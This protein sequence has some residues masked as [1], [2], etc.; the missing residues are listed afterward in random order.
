MGT[1]SYTYDDFNRL[2][3]G[4]AT[5]GVDNTLSL[6]WTYDRGPQRQ[7]FVAGVE[8]RYGNRWAQNASGSGNISAVQPQ[9]S[10][11]NANQVTGWSYDADGNLLNDQRNSYAYDAE[12]RIVSLNGSPTYLYDAE[13]RR[14]AKYSGGTISASYLL[15]L[16][17]DQVTELNG[18][19]AWNHSNVWAGAHLDATYDT[20]GLHFHLA[21]PLG[22]RRVQTNVYGVT[23]VS[24]QSLPFGD[25]LTSVSNPNCLAANDCY[26]GD[27][28]TEH[29][30]TGKER[31]SESGNDYFEAR[32][33][34]SAMGRFL[35]PDWSAKEE[36]VP[37]A[38]LDNPQTLNLYA[39]VQNNPL[40]RVD[41]DGH[42]A[43]QI[44][45][46]RT[47]HVTI[48]IPVHMTGRGA[49]KARVHQILQR[50]NHLH[51]EDPNVTVKAMY[52][53]TPVHGVMNTLDISPR[54]DTAMCGAAGECVNRVGGD[55]GHIDSR[56]T[57][58]NDAGPHELEHFAGAKD[59]YEEGVDQ[60]GNRTT[61]PSPGYNETDIMSERPGTNLKPAD[62]QEMK[63]NQTTKKCST[64]NGQTTCN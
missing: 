14:V 63:Q 38:K 55:K 3:S 31:D 34:S 17:G 37:Y 13:G 62:T 54:Q 35:S 11:G 43:L 60:N 20:Y 8:D 22:T 2:T 56:Y 1:W 4:N 41:E 40:I 42:D 59:K 50:V 46:Q 19:G 18:S 33:Y 26:S 64:S 47:G 32:Y 29:H 49:T 51:S 24:F 25:G 45:D 44:V 12:G 36:P 53:K 16:G 52:T 61:H 30:F 21:D 27:D 58:D 48:L 5:A 9:L 6:S 10:F 28:S 7:V 23:E 15:D 39:Y 57:G